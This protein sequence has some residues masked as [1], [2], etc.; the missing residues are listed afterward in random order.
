MGGGGGCMVPDPQWLY[1][2]CFSVII[3][4]PLTIMSGT[5]GDS[6]AAK[7]YTSCVHTSMHRVYVDA[8]QWKLFYLQKLQ[9][10]DTSE[11]QPLSI[12]TFPL[13]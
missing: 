9:Y 13:P 3:S 7:P 5:E 4:H 10:A 8:T 1:I 2:D 12:S 6:R 11:Q